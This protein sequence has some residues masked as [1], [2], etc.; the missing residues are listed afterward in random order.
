MALFWK[1][2]AAVNVGLRQKVDYRDWQQQSTLS[3]RWKGIG[4]TPLGRFC[5]FLIHISLCSI[6]INCV[7]IF[8]IRD[9]AK[10]SF[11]KAA[12]H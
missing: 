5:G 4:Y 7:F 9:R 1:N 11:P 10:Y 2:D 6:L 12:I 3:R 8:R